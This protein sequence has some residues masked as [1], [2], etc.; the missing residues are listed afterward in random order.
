MKAAIFNKFGQLPQVCEVDDPK[1]MPT[2]VVVEVK[3][4]GICRSDWHAWMGH[5]DTVRLPHVPGHELS[6][7]V[8]EIGSEIRNVSVGDRVTVPF[9]CGCGQ[10]RYCR[11]GQLHICDHDFQPGFTHWGSFAQLVEIHHA[12]HNVVRLPNDLDFVSA[13]SLGCRFATAYRAVAQQANLNRGDWL[14]IHGCG[15]LGLS[16]LLIGKALGMRVVVVDIDPEKLELARQ[17]GADGVVNGQANENV[18]ELIVE[19]TAGGADASVDAL[20]SRLTASNSIC[21]LRKQGRH[22]QAGLLLGDQANPSLPIGRVI[23]RE[24]QLYGSHGMSAKDYPEMLQL[25]ST[26]RLNLDRLIGAKISLSQAPEVL[27]AMGDFR[28]IGVTVITDF[29]A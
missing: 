13:A 22:I 29:A 25:V 20:G 24:L 12:D 7:V 15:G 21:C 26:G 23:S 2:S 3:A 27:A 4:N 5:D 28:S 1:A 19:L 8:L 10:C 9:A 17:L 16:A 6:G 11:D 18:A 14:A